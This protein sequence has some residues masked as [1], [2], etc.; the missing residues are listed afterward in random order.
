MAGGTDNSHDVV[1]S[2]TGHNGLTCAGYLTRGGLSVK[3]V[4]PRAVVARALIIDLK[5]GADG[6]PE[7]Y[8]RVRRLPYPLFSFEISSTTLY[9]SDQSLAPWPRSRAAS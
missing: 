4:E 3:V 5:A 7:R 2:G 9:I 6:H 1:I 8:W